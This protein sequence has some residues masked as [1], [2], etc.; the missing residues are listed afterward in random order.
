MEWRGDWWRFL[1]SEDF[2]V[3]WEEDVGRGGRMEEAGAISLAMRVSMNVTKVKETL[4]A[5]E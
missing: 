3:W 2:L 5:G 4:W 1:S